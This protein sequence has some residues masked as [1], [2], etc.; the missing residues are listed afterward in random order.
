VV[1]DYWIVLPYQT[2]EGT[3][4]L[5]IALQDPFR[6]GPVTEAVTLQ[7]IEIGQALGG[8]LSALSYQ[9]LREDR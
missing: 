8:H 2:V 5:Q 3:Y 4:P 7:E 6:R 9:S 1:E